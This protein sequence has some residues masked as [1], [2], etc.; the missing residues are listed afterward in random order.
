[1][2][3]GEVKVGLKMCSRGYAGVFGFALRVRGGIGWMSE[4][5]LLWVVQ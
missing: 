4:L 3:R 1:M 5:E 2:W